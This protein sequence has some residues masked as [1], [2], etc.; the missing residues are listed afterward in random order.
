MKDRIFNVLLS[1]TVSCYDSSTKTYVPIYYSYIDKKNPRFGMEQ[2]TYRQ[3]AKICGIS[4]R[5]VSKYMAQLVSEGKAK[6]PEYRYVVGTVDCV[7]DGLRRKLTIYGG[8]NCNMV[9]IDNYGTIWEVFDSKSRFWA[10][11]EKFS[12]YGV[13]DEKIYKVSQF[14]QWNVNVNDSAWPGI[15]IYKYLQPKAMYERVDSTDKQYKITTYDK[16]I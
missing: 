4:Q 2:P 12:Y 5:E 7:L 11:M 6:K 9:W 8:G 10:S 1:S 3:I 13:S 16:K 15:E 14:G